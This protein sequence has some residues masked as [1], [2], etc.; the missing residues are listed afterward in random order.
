M[1][2][3]ADRTPFC[4]SDDRFFIKNSVAKF[5]MMGFK[6]ELLIQLITSEILM[7]ISAMSLIDIAGVE[8]LVGFVRISP[9]VICASRL[10]EKSSAHPL[11]H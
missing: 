10:V 7:I 1:V 5:F 4:I 6:S 2:D 9:D 11:R 3:F 8:V